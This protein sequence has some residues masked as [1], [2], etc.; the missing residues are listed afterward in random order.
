MGFKEINYKETIPHFILVPN[1]YF[2]S[3]Y[4]A[5]KDYFLNDKSFDSHRDIKMNLHWRFFT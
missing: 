5:I 1:V 2:Y 3:E 4:L